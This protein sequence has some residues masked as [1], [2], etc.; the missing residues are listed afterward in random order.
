MATFYDQIGA[1]KRN[2]VL[3]VLFV[4]LLLGALGLTVGC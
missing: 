3:L 1:N 4:V 2:S